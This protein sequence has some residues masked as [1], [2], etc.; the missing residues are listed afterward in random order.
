MPQYFDLLFKVAPISATGA[1]IDWLLRNMF[2]LL[3]ISLLA[4]EFH[5]Q[6][7]AY[8]VCKM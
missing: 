4:P 6:I 2:L 8:P 1:V 3:F 7:L 5:I